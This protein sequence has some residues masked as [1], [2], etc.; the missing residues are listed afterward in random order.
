MQQLIQ[1]KVNVAAVFRG[2]R[3]INEHGHGDSAYKRIEPYRF[4]RK[5]GNVYKIAEI[6]RSYAA[7]KGPNLHVHFVVKTT[8]ARFFEL[9]YDSAQLMW[10]VMYEFEDW[11]LIDK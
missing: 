9:V 10:I 11:S 8:D 6:R 7:R 4:K 1:E 3:D 2:F 5:N